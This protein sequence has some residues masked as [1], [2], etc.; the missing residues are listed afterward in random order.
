MLRLS[1]ECCR[2]ASVFSRETKALARAGLRNPATISVAVKSRPTG[3]DA[4][5]GG[6]ETQAT[7]SSLENFYI[8]CAP[9]EKLAQLLAFLEVGGRGRRR[10]NLENSN[11]DVPQAVDPGAGER[12]ESDFGGQKSSLMLRDSSGVVVLRVLGGVIA[13]L[14]VVCFSESTSTARL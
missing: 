14:V 7:P 1:G 2:G 13:L 4:T 5:T 6:H 3:G 9:E 12:R 8:T 11:L 10:S